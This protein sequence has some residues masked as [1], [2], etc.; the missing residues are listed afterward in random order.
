MS[1]DSD[2]IEVGQSRWF[3]LLGSTDYY[4][5]SVSR[6]AGEDGLQEADNHPICSYCDHSV[7]EWI[8]EDT[9]GT[10]VTWLQKDSL[11]ELDIPEWQKATL[12]AE[13]DVYLCDRCSGSSFRMRMR[14]TSTQDHIKFMRA[15]ID[16]LAMKL[17]RVREHAKYC[18]DTGFS[19]P[20]M[21]TDA[22]SPSPGTLAVDAWR[23]AG[24]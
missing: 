20:E 9:G 16:L 6:F 17:Y 18:G 2:D 21:K 8:E 14:E 5:N 15:V 23:A 10:L 1:E 4:P 13:D 11:K 19:K 24:L 3:T 7:A 22:S 12:L